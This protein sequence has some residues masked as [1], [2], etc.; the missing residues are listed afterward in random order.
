MKVLFFL[1]CCAALHAQ[2]R[3]QLVGVI[4]DATGATVPGTDVSLYNV[5]IGVRRSTR[6]DDH[7]FYA[8][9][10]LR[11]GHYKITVRRP[12]FRTISRTGILLAP[13]ERARV[14]FLLEIG[15]THEVVTV[16]GAAERINSNDAASL[17]IVSRDR[18]NELPLNNRGLQAIPEFVPGLVITPATRGEAGQFTANGQRPN[19]NYFTVDGV[20]VNNGVAGSGL[21][22]EFSAGALPGMTAIGS[23]HG[24]VASDEIDEVRVQTSTFAPEYGRLPGAQVSVL[25]RSGSNDFHGQF[26]AGWRPRQLGAADSFSKRAALEPQRAS[27]RSAGGLLSGPLVRD[28]L[29]FSA[30][31]EWLDVTQAA[32]WRMSVP[33]L[34]LRN[35]ASPVA[36]HVL[37]AYPTPH[38]DLTPFAAEHTAQT[39]WPGNVLT[40]S[41]RADFAITSNALAFIRYSRSGSESRAGY[42]QA[43]DARFTTQAVTAGVLHSFGPTIT[44]DARIGISSTSVDSSWRLLGSGGAEPLDIGSVLMPEAFGVR[45]VYALSVPGFGQFLSADRAR[46]RQA[47][48]NLM[49]TLAVNVNGHQLRFG[50]D[51]QRIM[52]ERE[53]PINGVV[54]V[55][56]SLADLTSGVPPTSHQ[57]YAA[58]GTSTIESFST[59]VQDTWHVTPR[60]NLTYG[61]RWEITPAPSYKGFP[62]G[63]SLMTTP[64]IRPPENFVPAPP[65]PV[66]R[67]RYTQFAPR[68]GAAYR[69]SRDGSFVLRAGT[70]LFYDLGFSSITDILNGV[71]FNRWTVNLASL[72]ATS[73]TP[74]Y[75]YAPDLRLPW[76]LHWNVTLEKQVTQETVASAAYVG[77]R[78]RRLL[79]IEATPEIVVAGNGGASD[80]HSLQFQVR[81]SLARRLRGFGAYTWAH[82]I[83]NGSWNSATFLLFPGASD[84]GS[85]DFDVRH[86][87]YS[88]VVYDV[89]RGWTLS[90][91]LRART[92]FPMDVLAQENPFGIL[93][94]NQ[95][96]DLVPGVPIWL[97]DR[98]NPA[99]FASPIAGQQGN[100]GR[101]SIR[102][103]GL[104]QLDLS[105]QRQ[106]SI[107]ERASANV[108]LE[109][110]NVTNRASFADPVRFLSSPLFGQSVSHTNLFLGT[111]RAH[112]GLTPSLQ[113]GGPRGIQ[114]RVDFR[115]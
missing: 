86:S 24:L 90:G 52:P 19:T 53:Q 109:A 79:R 20:S 107:G 43:N 39:V 21:P 25:T 60:L 74:G 63:N 94:D 23:L 3:A 106:F 13:T 108:R 71:P 73:T 105:L 80:Y 65:P 104:A 37:N 44:S 61:T 47:H 29:F 98:L 75:G 18:I 1:L 35:A 78:G 32:A 91:V 89:A 15:G 28:R 38:A 111:G 30:G 103:F 55:Y 46:S 100:L 40:N 17:E 112:S 45:T 102:G 8:V 114:L 50:I 88:G 41:F 85:S 57:L 48:W 42:V 64:V 26:F 113:S 58:S 10:S 66:W 11:A 83:D 34:A 87:F 70:G 110:Y 77:S 9:S 7:G 6:T 54:G 62:A 84:R 93:F 36:R 95:R 92:G 16:E 81:R 99:A 49:E 96:P 22:G 101:N 76:S 5:D 82:S 56:S 2:E 31:S 115:F 14:D 27:A 72:P 69:L 68:A 97:G 51:Y 12:G 59:F 67:T 33:S 4:R